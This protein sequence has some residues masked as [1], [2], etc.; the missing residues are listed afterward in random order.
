MSENRPVEFDQARKG[1]KKRKKKTDLFS[2]SMLSVKRDVSNIIKLVSSPAAAKHSAAKG[3]KREIENIFTY[4]FFFF[5]RS[6]PVTGPRRVTFF[7]IFR[8]N[9]IINNGT[10]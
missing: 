5:F 3:E 9:I 7:F 1:K 4:F 10:R 2:F 6:E 8:Q